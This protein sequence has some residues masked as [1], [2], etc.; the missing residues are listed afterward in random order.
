MPKGWGVNSKK[1]EAREKEKEKKQEINSKKAREA[2]DAKWAETDPKVL[3]K[4]AKKKEEEKKEQERKQKELEK[5][6]LYEEEQEELRKTKLKIDKKDLKT[7]KEFIKPKVA[8]PSAP[9]KAKKT[10]SDSE[11]IDQLLNEEFKSLYKPAKEEEEAQI[12]GTGDKHPEKR[13]KAAWKAYEEE[14]FERM[15]EEHP[16]LKRNQMLNLLWQEF[17][18]SNANPMNNV[19]NKTWDK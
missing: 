13:M 11:D 2:E 10:D 15:K 4:L 5:K 18:S 3:A 12:S 16:G 9:Q 19:A 14:H 17:K 7:V 6:K 1:E 8:E